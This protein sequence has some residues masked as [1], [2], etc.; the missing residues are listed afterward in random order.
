MAEH[1]DLLCTRDVAEFVARGFL[2]FDALIPDALNERFMR[3]C[4]SSTPESSPAGT[5]LADAYP[6][7]VLREILALPRVAG[8]IE[9]LV[10]PD[11]TFDHQGTHFSPPIAPFLEQGIRASNQHT[12]QDSTIDPRTTFDIQLMYFPHEV[13]SEMG[14]TRFVPG[15]HLRIVSEMAL[16]R[17]QNIRGQRRVVCPAGTLLVLHH[18]LW[19]GGM[20]NHSDRMR[21]M[22]KVRLNPTVSQSLRWNTDDLTPE[23]SEPQVIFDFK[24]KHDPDSGDIQ[25]ILCRPEPWFELDTGRLEF[26]NRIKLW[27]Y[28]TGDPDFDAHYWCTRIENVPG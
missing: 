19:H 18:G 13:T 9:S 7:S 28:L 1:E 10:G 11:P 5:P 8:I 6:N 27:R 15:T 14:G 16:A 17:Y 12:H 20:L 21:Y 24:K 4:E 3:D 23:M 25:S 26:I 22:L 2:R